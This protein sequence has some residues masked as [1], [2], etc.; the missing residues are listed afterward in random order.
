MK[1]EDTVGIRYQATTDEDQEDL[2]SAVV[3]TRLRELV[4]AL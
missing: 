4:R 3:I 1:A 2:A